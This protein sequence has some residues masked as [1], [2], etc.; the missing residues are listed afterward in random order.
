M[1]HHIT[2]SRQ[3]WRQPFFILHFSF[4]IFLLAA[5]GG[6]EV[7]QPKPRAYLRI[8]M[9][10]HNYIAVDSLRLPDS[11]GGKTL[12]LPYCFEMNTRAQI[13]QASQN[14]QRT[15]LIINYPEWK[16]DVE[17]VCTH[18][19][20][21][22]DLDELMTIVHRNLEREHQKASGDD[23]VFAIDVPENNVHATIW[24]V[25]G[26]DVA[27]TYL[28]TVT[29]STDHFL[30]GNVIINQVPNNDSLAPMLEYMRADV[31]HLI[32][33]LHWR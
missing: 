6:D 32:G 26:R 7:P 20:G 23:D 15:G 12:A 14:R 28:F 9:P 33:T 27:C 13:S 16:G 30:F 18:I 2:H 19:D 1:K 21:S 11:L 8:D 10:E 4:F 22:D 17:M 3:G 24:Q 29:D 5:C 31:D 25:N